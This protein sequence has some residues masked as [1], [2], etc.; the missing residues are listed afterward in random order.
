MCEL[1]KENMTLLLYKLFTHL[2][3][4][5]QWLNDLF[6]G[7]G[8][9][10]HSSGMIYEGMWVNGHPANMAQRL[11]V[12]ATPSDLVQGVYFSVQVQ[13]VTE[14]GRHV[15]TGRYLNFHYFYT[16]VIMTLVVIDFKHFFLYLVLI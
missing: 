13:C 5:G 1:C 14:D 2:Y 16:T 7:Q 10:K 11:M 12:T 6:N 3:F 4:Q 9:M 8:T 15:P